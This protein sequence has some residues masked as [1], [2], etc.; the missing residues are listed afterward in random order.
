VKRNLSLKGIHKA[1]K[2]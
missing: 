1:T 2:D